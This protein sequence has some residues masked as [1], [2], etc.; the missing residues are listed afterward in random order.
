M[1]EPDFPPT[2]ENSLIAGK[3]NEVV[4]QHDPYVMA[5]SELDGKAMHSSDD[6]DIGK[7]KEIILDVRTGRIAYVVLSSGGFFGMGDKLQAIPWHVLTLDAKHNCFRLSASSEKFES[8][9]GF[10]KDNWP[11]MAD[12][13]WANSIHKFYGTEP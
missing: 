12:Q 8:A 3:R 6:K 4:E 10:P 7:V 13:I 2:G 5:A 1:I 9:P 11:S